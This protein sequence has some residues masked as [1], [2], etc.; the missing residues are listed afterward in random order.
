MRLRL[1]A[2]FRRS[3]RPRPARGTGRAPWTEPRHEASSPGSP[4]PAAIAGTAGGR[5]SPTHRS[6]AVGSGSPEASPLSSPVGDVLPRRTRPRRPE[7]GK[8]TGYGAG[9][10]RAAVRM[11]S[12]AR[13]DVRPATAPVG[14]AAGGGRPGR[15]PLV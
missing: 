13:P 8:G 12:Q 4:R 1:F 10:A 2:R 6:Q 7:P 3:A 5:R 14:A 11:T 15:A 9:A